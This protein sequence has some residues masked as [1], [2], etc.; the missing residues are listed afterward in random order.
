MLI[1]KVSYNKFIYANTPTTVATVI[2]NEKLNG[3][4]TIITLFD[5]DKIVERKNIILSKDGINNISFTYKPGEYG[6]RKLKI[7]VN[8][9]SGEENILNNSKTFYI[10]VQKS[11]L[12]VLIIAGSPS[13]DLSIIKSSLKDNQNY[14][15][16][17]LTQIANDRFLEKENPSKLLDSSD[18]YFLIG[19]LSSSSSI[20]CI[21]KVKA[22]V[23]NNKKPFLFLLGNSV[24]ADKL[25]YLNDILSFK[26]SFIS[27][28]LDAVLPSIKKE[29][30]TNPILQISDAD[31]L[32]S[33]STLPPVFQPSSDYEVKPGSNILSRIIINNIPLKRPL[34]ISRKIAGNKSISI[35]ASGIWRWKLLAVANGENVFDKFISNCVK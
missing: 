35:L 15:V 11:K 4:K 19:C 2:E 23:I 26:T 10:S 5:E 25:N 14:E 6:E 32:K 7:K 22:A 27:S 24:D 16:N 13:N 17:S 33:W 21:E 12:R 18:V 30:I 8:T 20:S 28:K 3:I 9:I 29:E 34:I 1:K 31:V